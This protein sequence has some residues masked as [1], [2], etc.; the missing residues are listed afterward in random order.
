MARVT[1]IRREMNENLAHS[2]PGRFGAPGGRLCVQHCKPLEGV[3]HYLYFDHTCI[4]A[5]CACRHACVATCCGRMQNQDCNHYRNE[6]LLQ[7]E[8][9]E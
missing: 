9:G 8:R 4:T 3:C 6:F 1:S 5:E 2:H 7:E